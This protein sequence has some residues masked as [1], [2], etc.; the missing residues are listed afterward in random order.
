MLLQSGPVLG[1]DVMVTG[2]NDY[3]PTADSDVE[4]PQEPRGGHG[5]RARQRT[6]SDVHRTAVRELV[7]I[8]EKKRA[9]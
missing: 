3:G 8:L 4:V 5:G 9:G 6:V 1:S 2:A 7:D